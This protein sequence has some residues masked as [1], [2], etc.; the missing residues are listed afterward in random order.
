[1]QETFNSMKKLAYILIGASVFAFASCTKDLDQLPVSSVTTN[2]FYTNT[3]DFTQAVNGV[4]NRLRSYPTQVLWMRE[5]RSDNVLATSDGN[6]DWQGINDFSPNLT[7]TGFITSTWSNGMNGIYN[8]NSVM[9][10]IDAKGSVIS[11]DSLRKRFMA[12]CRFLRAFYTFDL[13]RYY[14]K[15]PI[16]DKAYSPTEASAIGRS[17]VADV[18]NF[19]ITDLQYAA[20]NLPS[21]YPAA[22]RGRATKW[23]AKGLLGLVYLTK[24]GPTYGVE[25]PGL[26]S[27]EYDKALAQFNDVINSGQFQFSS[28]FP[29]I[30]S[31]TN[32]N[33]A[34][35]LFDVQFTNSTN[36][37]EFPS[38]L[39]P[40]AYWTGLGLS[41]YNNGYGTA[42]YNIS[43]NMIQSY[44]TSAGTVTDR[45]DTFSI[46]YGWATSTSTPNVLDTT[47][48][49]VKKYIDVA[50]RGTG[51][52]DWPINFIVM[53]YTDILMMKAEC[54]L[55]GATGTQVEVNTI[56]N[57]VR[58]R[59]GIAALTGNV[60]LE[61]LM[62]E[63]RREFLG[64]G[65]RWNDLVRSGLAITTMNAWRTAEGVTTINPVTA[66][67]IIYPVPQSEI[68]AK[69]GLYTQNPGYN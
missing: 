15:V 63:R 38:Q 20:D 34:E 36:G 31:Y 42:T 60:T 64:E 3:N 5:L 33:N 26:N 55:R 40:E 13:V 45:R 11:S 54:I 16:L 46:K 35:V 39:V 30:F 14:G 53:R 43:K 56:V 10:A 24:S 50:R 1:M 62:E 28:S 51:R 47:R 41:G 18:Y 6:R 9:E 44:R 48:P 23:S 29:N 65:L 4:Y 52:A 67:Y 17:S 37:A 25:G 69:P 61:T 8:A 2:V 22:E 58:T 59:A 32:E 19:I 7:N 27:N 66:N 57:Q 49:F 12:E 68:L 21:T